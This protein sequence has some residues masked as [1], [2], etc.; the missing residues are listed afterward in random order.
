VDLAPTLYEL[1]RVKPGDEPTGTSL[2]RLLGRPA[3]PLSGSAWADNEG[4]ERALYRGE[5]KALESLLVFNP[6][7]GARVELYD[8]SRDP[9]QRR[10]LSRERTRTTRALLRELLAF[11]PRPVAA[12]SVA[13]LDPEVEKSLRALGYLQ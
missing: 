12:A 13:P 11:N 7:S 2:A 10:D 5:Q 8:V 4:G 6:P 1:A 9:G 3:A